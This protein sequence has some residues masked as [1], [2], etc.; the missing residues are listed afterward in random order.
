MNLVL[1]VVIIGGP[2]SLWLNVNV[3][4]V[5]VEVLVGTFGCQF[6]HGVASNRLYFD[7]SC[8]D[9]HIGITGVH[10]IL[11]LLFLLAEQGG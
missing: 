7:W 11:G 5:F 2:M 4:I 1:I 6:V 3:D 8:F 10:I 9:F